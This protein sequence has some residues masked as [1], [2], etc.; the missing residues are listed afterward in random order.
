MNE[1][2]LAANISD[3]ELFVG[4]TVVKQ[5]L[6]SLCFLTHAVLEELILGQLYFW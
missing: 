4:V 3:A 6:L 2:C 1:F 5:I